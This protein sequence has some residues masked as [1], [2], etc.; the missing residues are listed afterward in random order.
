[1]SPIRLPVAIVTLS[2][3]LSACASEKNESPTAR[4]S[5]APAA[6]AAP[7]PPPSG[8]IAE[9]AV[10]ATATVE[11]VDLAKRHVTLKGP[12]GRVFTVTAGPEVKNLAQ[13]KK[14]DLV[15]VVYYESL[16]YEVK[17]PG[18]AQPGAS[19]TDVAAAARPGE[20]P[21]GAALSQVT[22]TTTIQAIDPSVP[23]VTLQPPDGDPIT[24]KVRDPAKLA[25]VSVGDLVEITY[26]EALAVA[27]EPATRK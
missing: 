23:S 11:K 8:T 25:R 20:R 27:V 3:A 21:A 12:N 26:S 18:E 24:V 13:V 6:A 16:A 22:V 1:M 15:N 7:A 5:A 19:V 2:L 4:S 10:Q 9:Q 14:G 17:R